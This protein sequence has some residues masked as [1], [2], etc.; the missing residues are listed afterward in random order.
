MKIK[1]KLTTDELLYLEK[2]SY[3][4]AGIHINDLP[5]EKRSTYTIMLDVADK[6]TNKGKSVNRQ[7]TIGKGK[8]SLSLKWHEAETLEMYLRGL[9]QSETDHY[10]L[11]II[12]KVTSQIN[13][14][15]A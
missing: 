13:Q 6:V 4:V 7:M 11:N 2:K 15:L 12:R 8:H 1:I 9:E 5:K 3:Y 10:A 14:K